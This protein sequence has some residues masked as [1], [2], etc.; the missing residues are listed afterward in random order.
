ML[1]VSTLLQTLAP[2]AGARGAGG[3]IPPNATLASWRRLFLF[4]LRPWTEGQLW[5]QLAERRITTDA[6]VT[7][8]PH[9]MDFM[10]QCSA[11]CAMRSLVLLCRSLMW[12]TLA[13]RASGERLFSLPPD[14][15][16][17]AQVQTTQHLVPC[18]F[19]HSEQH[20]FPSFSDFSELP[21]VVC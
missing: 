12:S 16:L 8:N 1:P 14:Q 17:M 13:C 3:V 2:A 20:S 9:A 6:F 11:V 19:A 4:A 18:H 5:L 15:R 10:L 7:A 21:C